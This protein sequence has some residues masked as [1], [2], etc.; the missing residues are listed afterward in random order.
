MSPPAIIYLATNRVTGKR[1]VGLTRHPL[2]VRFAGHVNAARRGA[3]SY[4]HRALMKYGPEAFNVEPIAS[5]LK[6]EDAGETERQLIVALAPEYN[7]T[8]GGEITLG[9]R[10]PEIARRVAEKN[11]GKKRTPQQRALN[12]ALAKERYRS[13]PTWRAAITESLSRARQNVD[14][15]KRNAAAGA[16]ARDRVWTPESRAKLSASCTG[17][18]YGQEV[19]DRISAS[20]NKAVF[21]V[22]TGAT[23]KSV[24]EAAEATGLSISGVSRVCRGERRR[25]N[26][27]RFRF[28]DATP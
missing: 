20:K 22:N 8:K 16:S 26:G 1:Y 10:D 7:Q 4:F 18:R 11:R 25:A 23:F 17:R 2:A 21:C 15:G 5:V 9:R 6:V 12:S 14:V 28:V 3:R 27:I 19:L 13:D 24:S